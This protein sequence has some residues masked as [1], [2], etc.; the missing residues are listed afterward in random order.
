MTKGPTSCLCSKRGK[1][2]GLCWLAQGRSSEASVNTLLQLE[3]VDF[4]TPLQVANDLVFCDRKV[5]FSLGS[6]R[7]TRPGCDAGRL[8]NV[9]VSGE[10]DSNGSFSTSRQTSVFTISFAQSSASWWYCENTARMKPGHF[11][12]HLLLKNCLFFYRIILKSGPSVHL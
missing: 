9:S 5:T 1:E 8:E 11:I 10:L 6:D 12:Q 4:I 3:F 2:N 7:E